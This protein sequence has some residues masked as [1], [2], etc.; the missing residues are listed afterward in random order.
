MIQRLTVVDPR[1][2]GNDPRSV[3]YTTTT[4]MVLL[5]LPWFDLATTI[6]KHILQ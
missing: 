4:T 6:L 5:P 2:A 3:Y 1:F